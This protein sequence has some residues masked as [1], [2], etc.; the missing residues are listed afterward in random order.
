MENYENRNFLN[1]GYIMKV[2]IDNFNSSENPGNLVLLKKIQNA[3]GDYFVYVSG[4]AFRYYLK[5]TLMQLG[6]PLTK[7]DSNGEFLIDKNAPKD[8]RERYKYILKNN[9]DLDLFGFME[10]K[11]GGEKMALRRWSPIKVSPLISIYPWNGEN[12]LLTQKKEGRGELIKVEIN[13]FNFMRGTAVINVNEVGGYV[14]ELNLEIEDIIG[15]DKRKERIGKLLDSFKNINGGGKTARLLDDLTPKFI[16]IAKQTAAVPVF[17]NSLAVDED[18]KLAI[19][20]I[21]DGLEIYSDIINNYVIGLRK[22][23]FT[24]EEEI[25][26]NFEENKVFDIKSAIEKAKEWI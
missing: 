21:K 26:S 25:K 5:Q 8:P 1:M 14:D 12:D 24:N 17:L 4:Q 10:A 11:K 3:R 23:I 9:P 6:M 18:G 22:G 19:D 7:I 2:N 15:E 16:I 13:V 20:L